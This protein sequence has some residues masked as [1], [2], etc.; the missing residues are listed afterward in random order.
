[1]PRRAADVTR[2]TIYSR[3]DCHLCAEMKAVV[4]VVSRSIPLHIEEVDISQDAAREAKYGLEI[5]VREIEGR[6][7]ATYR[8]GEDELRRILFA[9]R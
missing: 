9:R 4:D 2:V 7:A 1:V 3:P 5:P 8:V 6:K